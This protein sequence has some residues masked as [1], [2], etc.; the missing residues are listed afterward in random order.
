MC[1]IIIFIINKK[2]N[3]PYASLPLDKKLDT[4]TLAFVKVPGLLLSLNFWQ[5]FS[6]G[7]YIVY[8]WL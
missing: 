2:E 6:E 7:L 8:V 5:R 1:I 3:A 4:V